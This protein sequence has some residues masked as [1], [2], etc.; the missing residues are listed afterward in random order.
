MAKQVVE[1]RFDDEIHAPVRLRIC[2]ALAAVKSV[3]FAALRDHLAVADSV[4][5]KHLARLEDA[6]YVAIAK[7]TEKGRQRTWAS[8]TP[9]GRT[10]LAGHLAALRELADQAGDGV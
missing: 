7:A 1:P 8:L 4:L 5:S 3:E 10:A 2:A 6:G 9:A